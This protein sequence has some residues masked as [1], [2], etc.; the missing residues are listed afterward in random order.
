MST[1]ILPYNL[2]SES[3]KDLADVMGIKRL[4]REHSVYKYKDGDVIINWGCTSPSKNIPE[5]AFVINPFSAVENATDKL[6]AFHILSDKRVNVPPYTTDLDLVSDWVENGYLV[7]G[8]KKVNGYGGE[9]IVLMENQDD[10]EECPLYTRYIPKKSEYRVHV[11][12]DNVIAVARKTLKKD[13]P[14]KE[15]INWRIRN[16]DGG[17]VF[18][19]WNERAEQEEQYVCPNEVM[20]QAREA[21]AALGLDFGAVDVIWNYKHRKAY[22]L[23]VNTA[24]GLGDNMCEKYVSAINAYIHRP[25]EPIVEKRPKFNLIPEVEEVFHHALN[26]PEINWEAFKKVVHNPRG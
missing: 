9:G 22:V 15:N 25:Q 1:Y 18:A 12:R 8:R 7:V 3:A 24:P 6:K 4:R 2:A 23:E 26:E 21:V 19:Y 13:H 14:N 20:F 10:I 11:V 17:F 5:D 16:L